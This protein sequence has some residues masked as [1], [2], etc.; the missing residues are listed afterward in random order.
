MKAGKGMS[1]LFASPRTAGMMAQRGRA[2]FWAARERGG[3]RAAPAPPSPTPFLFVPPS[4]FQTTP[5]PHGLRLIQP[6]QGASRRL[7]RPPGIPGAGDAGRGPVGRVRRRQVPGAGRHG[8]HMALPV[9][10]RGGGVAW[11]RG[12]VDRW[13]AGWCTGQRSSLAVRWA[14]GGWRGG[15]AAAGWR[16]GGAGGAPPLAGGPRAAPRANCSPRRRPF[17]GAACPS[18]GLLRT[19]TCTPVLP[20]LAWNGGRPELGGRTGLWPAGRN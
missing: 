1:T 10:V 18:G 16:A 17:S 7:L 3:R 11:G 4:P 14:A 12:G 2:R 15:G 20:C 9:R 5:H 6:G 8:R 19:S 13:G